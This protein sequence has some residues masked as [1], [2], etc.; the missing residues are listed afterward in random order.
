MLDLRADL[1]CYGFSLFLFVVQIQC[2]MLVI[3]GF[4]PEVVS[5][6]RLNLN[7]ECDIICTRICCPQQYARIQSPPRGV[8]FKQ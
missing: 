4:Y 5:L 3:P 2:F 6:Q 8:I 1:H 7:A